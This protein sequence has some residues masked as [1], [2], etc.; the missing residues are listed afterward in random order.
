MSETP[1]RGLFAIIA[2]LVLWAAAQVA[3]ADDAAPVR[4]A[5]E[6]GVP[7]EAE[8]REAATG[9]RIYVPLHPA[10]PHEIEEEFAP[11]RTITFGAPPARPAARVGSPAVTPAPPL[12]SP[13]P[14]RQSAAAPD[15]R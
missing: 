11:L 10:E 4:S 13:P 3:R 14:D 15:G 8:T 1:R 5:S 7:L 2:L 6:F 12:A 9:P